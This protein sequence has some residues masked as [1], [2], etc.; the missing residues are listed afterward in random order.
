MVATYTVRFLHNDPGSREWTNVTKILYVTEHENPGKPDNWSLNDGGSGTRSPNESVYWGGR[1][2]LK[3]KDV[4]PRCGWLGFIDSLL[5]D[6][7][8]F[9]DKWS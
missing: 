3:G 1:A 4:G 5:F 8:S 6:R 2:A 9:C 7:F